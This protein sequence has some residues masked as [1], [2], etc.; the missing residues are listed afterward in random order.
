MGKTRAGGSSSDQRRPVYPPPSPTGDIRIRGKDD[1]CCG[2]FFLKYLL[3]VF[4]VI[5]LLSGVAVL[6]VGLWTLFMK[7]SLVSLLASSFFTVTT[8]LLIITGGLIIILVFVLGCVG[9]W[10]ENYVLL[11]A[12][13]VFLLLIFMLEAATG[14]IA[15]L[16]E[17]SLFGELSHNLNVTMLES[18]RIDESKT[19]AIDNMQQQFHCCGAGNFTDWYYRPDYA[20]AAATIPTLSYKSCASRSADGFASVDWLFGAYTDTDGRLLAVPES[21]CIS[22]CKGC[23]RRIHPSNIFYEGCIVSLEHYYSEHLIIIGAIGLGLCCLQIFGIVFSCCLAK[24]VKE[25]K[26]RQRTS[27]R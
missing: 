23:S 6:G 20:V 24:K 21:C 9:A 26:E 13:A 1:S 2:V 4:N 16:Y 7:H 25:W 19:Q 5:L 12:Y 10:R 8:Y 27:W 14:V 18:Y 17:A 11:M 3:Y 22:P 15:Y